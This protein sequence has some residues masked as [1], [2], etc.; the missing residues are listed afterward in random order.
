MEIRNE[1]EK[2]INAVISHNWLCGET[3]VSGLS[4][5]EHAI[6]IFID[7]C[8]VFYFLRKSLSRIVLSAGSI[9]FQ[10]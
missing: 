2:S 7:I 6:G 1:T 4:S 5:S 9:A 10:M 3:L 8:I